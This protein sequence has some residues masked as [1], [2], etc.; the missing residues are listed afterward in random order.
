MQMMS[1][2]MI[3][4]ALLVFG[5]GLAGCGDDGESGGGSNQDANNDSDPEN[6]DDGQD[7]DDTN[8]DTDDG[9]DGPMEP[10][11]PEDLGRSCNGGCNLQTCALE[12]DE[13]AGG[14]CVWD[15]NL[16]AAYCSR[17]CVDTCPD[18]YNC[19][20][21]EDVLEFEEGGDPV[22]LSNPPVC[23]NNTLEAGEACDDGNTE[24]ED[25]CSS[26]CRMV[27]VPPSGGTITQTIGDND[28]TT[29]EGN[30]PVVF[31]RRQGG[32]LFL[33]TSGSSVG[34][35]I[36]LPDDAGPAPFEAIGEVGLAEGVC[37]LNASTRFS[38]TR[39]DAETKE[40]AGNA[41]GIM[42]C[43]FGCDQGCVPQLSF[44]IEF[45]VR[46]VDE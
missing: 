17:P 3:L 26:D 4:A 31:A 5:A 32:R 14:V 44:S 11:N 27:T 21:T 23:G 18:G 15:G 35:G 30:D 36:D 7:G 38:I 20:L 28:P 25:F 29:S 2:R 34:Y 22:C 41:A 12:S 39:Y 9:Q 43:I 46:W 1:L 16:G 40:I 8:N 19:T 10:E 42:G 37:Q 24:N 33:G 45:D 13:C 6:N